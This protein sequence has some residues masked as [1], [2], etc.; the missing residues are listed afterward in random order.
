MSAAWPALLKDEVDVYI[1][2]CTHAHR[3][4]DNPTLNVFAFDRMCSL[5]I[6]C[7]SIQH[8]DIPKP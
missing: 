6:P 5:W 4:G 2:P 7:M 1:H 3:Q 8:T